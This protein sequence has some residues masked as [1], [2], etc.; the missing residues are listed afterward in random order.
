MLKYVFIIMKQM[1]MVYEVGV[2]RCKVG[3]RV[4]EILVYGI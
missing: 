2:I 1:F 3:V 4:F